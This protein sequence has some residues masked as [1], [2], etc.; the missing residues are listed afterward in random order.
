MANRTTR[1]SGDTNSTCFL[2]PEECFQY[3]HSLDLADKFSNAPNF[4]DQNAWQML[5]K[6]RRSK[7]EVEFKV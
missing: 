6:M 5:C 2:L 7:I 4:I 3:L 1:T